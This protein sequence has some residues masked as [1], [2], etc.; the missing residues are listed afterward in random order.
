MDSRPWIISSSVATEKEEEAVAMV[1]SC[2]VV[3]KSV[4]K[5]NFS[6][7]VPLAGKS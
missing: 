7:T 6:S 2:V 1:L 3:G 5:R 4:G